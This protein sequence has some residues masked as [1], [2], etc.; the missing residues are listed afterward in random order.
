MKFQLVDSGEEPVQSGTA[1]PG[2]DGA[3]R[4]VDPPR[5]EAGDAAAADHGESAETGGTDEAEDAEQGPEARL[6][7]STRRLTVQVKE[8]AAEIGASLA[9]LAQQIAD[10]ESAV[11]DIG[12]GP[13]PAPSNFR[14]DRFA[15]QQPGG[16]ADP[17]S[18]AE[19]APAASHR[20]AARTMEPEAHRGRPTCDGRR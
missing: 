20:T 11:A 19:S 10:R 17:A 1:V 13:T 16:A 4:P 9:E 15:S 14:A 12:R 2:E 18:P 3:E 7:T 5:A 6:R 8:E